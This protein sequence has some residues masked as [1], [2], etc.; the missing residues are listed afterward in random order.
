M[1]AH[2]LDATREVEE[3]EPPRDGRQG[4]VPV[5]HRLG[6]VVEPPREVDDDGEGEGVEDQLGVE[7]PQVEGR[8]GLEVDPEG[9][10]AD[11]QRGGWGGARGQ[12]R[13]RDIF[14]ALGHYT[15]AVAAS[16]QRQRD[17]SPHLLQG[18]V[19]QIRGAM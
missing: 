6:W 19:K 10:Q 17:A 5:G 16:R 13:A 9:Q 12:D 8:L 2:L 7:Q 14:H 1:H 15:T 11:G 3:V 4:Q 18:A